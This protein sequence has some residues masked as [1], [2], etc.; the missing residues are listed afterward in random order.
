[1]ETIKYGH[2]ENQFGE[3]RIPEG[4]GPHPVAI[5]I[6]GG[7][8][9]AGFGLDL[10]EDVAVDLTKSGWATWTIEYRRTG[11]EGG[12]WPGT[13]LDVAQ[14]SDYVRTL[15]HTYPL[16]LDN[17]VTIGHSAGG[18]L[19]LW[20]AAR[21]KLQ[22]GSELHTENPLPIATAVS[23]AGVNDL[24]KMHDVHAFRDNTLSQEPNNPVADLLRG[25]PEAHYQEASPF[26]MLPLNVT[27]VLVHGALDVHVPI[28][29]SDHY[30]QWAENMG[31]FI[32]YIEL[33]EAEHFMLT[34][35]NTKAWSRIREEMDLLK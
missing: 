22:E 29:I 35:T 8:W 7:F 16:N 23:L 9:R 10:M 25:E 11:Q 32:K 2:N 14:A 17:V 5:V 27:Q 33:P 28:G 15:A 3:L 19:A 18:H 12:G 13:L 4:N 20:T 31:D 1:M 24:K 21:H 34:D 30:F 6:H 26:E